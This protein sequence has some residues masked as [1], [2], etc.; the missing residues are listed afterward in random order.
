MA[1]AFVCIPHKR[2]S[3]D[4]SKLELSHFEDADQRNVKLAPV[5]TNFTCIIF[6]DAFKNQ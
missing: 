6:Q 4:E 1:K 2:N 3:S 5:G